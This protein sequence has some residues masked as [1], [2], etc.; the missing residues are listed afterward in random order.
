MATETNRRNTAIEGFRILLMLGIVTLHFLG[1]GGGIALASNDAVSKGF[2]WMLES[3]AYFS[4]N[5][6]VLITGYFQC[7]QQFKWKKALNLIVQITFWSIICYALTV[8]TG[9]ESFSI[10]AF[11]KVLFPWLFW[12]YWF[13]S[14]YLGVY[15]L[16]PYLNKIVYGL[17]KVTV[18]SIGTTEQLLEKKEYQILLIVVTILF[19]FP[20]IRESIGLGGGKSLLWF[21]H[22][23]ISA[24]FF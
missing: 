22:L 3:I 23:Y 10:K 19:C 1:H 15:L 21:C 17:E 5:G 8:L 7:T 20:F 11:V 2:V 9:T 18:Q 6:F 13:P 4:V 16:S 24:G 12:K 14:V